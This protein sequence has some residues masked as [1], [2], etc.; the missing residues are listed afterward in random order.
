MLSRI[1][2][3]VT[4]ETFFR[5]YWTKKFLHISGPAEKFSGLYN[6]E[7]LN[8]ALEEH[9]FTP[10]RLVLFK[11]GKPIPAA[12]YMN[13]RQV[14][15]NRFVNELT[16][17]ATLILN[18]CDEFYP[19]LREFCVFLEQLTH[20]RVQTNLYAGWREDHGFNVH[21]DTQ[22]VLILQIYGRKHWK[23]WNPTRLYPFRSD[24]VDTS[25]KTIPKEAP[26]W[27]GVLEPGAMLNIPRGWWHIATPMDE[28]C[29]HLTVTVCNLNGINFLGWFREKKLK[30]K[31]SARMELPVIATVA[32]QRMWLADLKKDID[33]LWSE[34]LLDEFMAE[35]DAEAI[36]RP[37]LSLPGDADRRSAGIQLDT[38]VKLALARPLHFA[39]GNETATFAA[40]GSE[41]EV[42]Q[43]VAEKL[44]KF[45]DF[46]PHTIK[47][48][49]PEPDFRVVTIVMALARS[50][51][52]RR[53]T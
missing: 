18:A 30:S 6:W 23:V 41:W 2:F 34:T 20:V 29:L 3:P 51:V 5:E 13:E 53:L 19:P 10:D 40:N 15:S 9:Q 28:P 37:V 31:E 47:E 12:S 1:L 48:L 8:R 25:E 46:L 35:K 33:E 49:S 50:E 7:T 21:W 27:E 38:P 24:V 22:D 32:E 52:L 16:N 42:K 36:A 4:E 11:N 44:R 43:S 17:G 39:Y 26:I 14:N 45:N